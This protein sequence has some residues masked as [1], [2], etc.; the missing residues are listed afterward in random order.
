MSNVARCRFSFKGGPPIE[1]KHACLRAVAAAGKGLGPILGVV[2]VANAAR[3]EAYFDQELVARAKKY[4]IGI[5]KLAKMMGA[6]NYEKVYEY[7]TA[8]ER[9]EKEGHARG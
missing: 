3:P 9:K 7:E 1:G 8:D 6:M 4:K 2:T 5:G